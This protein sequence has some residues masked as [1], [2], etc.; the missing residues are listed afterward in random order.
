[1]D[2]QTPL[3]V[4][5]AAA[6]A[7]WV[8]WTAA[9]PFLRRI[10]GCGPCPGCGPVRVEDTRASAPADALLEIAPAQPADRPA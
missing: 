4:A 1:M 9:R 7:L 6:G 3:T 10:A 2:W 5:A 8:L